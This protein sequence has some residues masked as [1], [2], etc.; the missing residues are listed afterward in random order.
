MELTSGPFP[1][2]EEFNPLDIHSPPLP[3]LLSTSLIKVTVHPRTLL[4]ILPYHP[5]HHHTAHLLLHHSLHPTT[6]PP[7][8]HPTTHPLSLHPTTHPPS[9]RRTTLPLS[10]P[11]PMTVLPRN[12]QETP[13]PPKFLFYLPQEKVVS[14]QPE[15][16]SPR[17][18][19]ESLPPA[20]P[21]LEYFHKLTTALIL[22]RAI[23]LIS[24]KST[25][26]V[27]KT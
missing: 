12:P 22:T 14:A 11:L 3:T 2:E 21:V 26:N 18:V 19:L 13:D 6:H 23:L 15:S 24:T 7:Y 25:Y 5:L 17:L 1:T 4:R 16:G 20:L 8:H 10:H 9:L 27:P